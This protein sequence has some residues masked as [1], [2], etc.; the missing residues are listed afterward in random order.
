MNYTIVFTIPFCPFVCG[1]IYGHAVGL[2]LI[3]ISAS[4]VQSYLWKIKGLIRIHKKLTFE[5]RKMISPDLYYGV[6]S[7]GFI[8]LFVNVE[9][10]PDRQRPYSENNYG[11]LYYEVVS[12]PFLLLKMYL[13][14]LGAI[15]LNQCD[16]YLLSDL[17]ADEDTDCRRSTVYSL[18]NCLPMKKKTY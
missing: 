1:V 3:Q 6:V 7:N 16:K 15:I 13:E 14:I 8:S 12:S 11:T 2:N 17:L 18:S 4:F 10:G 5:A 9:F